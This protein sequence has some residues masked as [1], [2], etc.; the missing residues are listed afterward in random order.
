V[1]PARIANNVYC[2]NGGCKYIVSI[3]S[4]SILAICIYQGGEHSVGKISENSIGR[5]TNL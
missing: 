4:L 3:F 5:L 2:D 1:L